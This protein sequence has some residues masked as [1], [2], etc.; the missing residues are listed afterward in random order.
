MKHINKWD[1]Y[2]QN[3]GLSEIK[4]R[5]QTKGLRRVLRMSE[6]ERRLEKTV[7]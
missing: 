4:E 3:R 6:P 7:Q 1:I 2:L 5:T